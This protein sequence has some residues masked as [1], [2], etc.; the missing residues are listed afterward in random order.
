MITNPIKGLYVHIPFC[1]HICSYCDFYKLVNPKEHET[2]VNYLLKE[3]EQKKEF[4]K[5]IET[6]YIGG[7]TPSCLNVRLLQKIIHSLSNVLSLD[8]IN[9]W[10]IEVDPIHITSEW[11]DFINSTPITRLSIG[12]Q[13]LNN[14][15]LKR[16][17]RL[18]QKETALYALEL[19]QNKHFDNISVD[20]IYGFEEDSLNELTEEIQLF[21]EKNVKHISLYSL[22]LEEHTLL[23]QQFKKGLFKPMPDDEETS[24][25]D[26]LSMIL[27]NHEYLPYEIS[28][29][30][31]PGYE[32]KHN[33]IYWNN[34][35][36]LGIGAGASYYIDN[37]R[38]TMT[39]KLS[40][41]YQGIDQESYNFDEELVLSKQEQMEEEVMLGLRKVKGISIKHFQEKFNENIFNIYP[42]INSLLQQ[43][44]LQLQDEYLSIPMNH[45]YISNAILVH[46]FS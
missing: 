6:V 4:M 23:Y 36:Y 33:L 27:K 38:Y 8:Q 7:G 40:S 20:L 3:I 14:Q 42:N 24:L 41:Y 17:K 11:I 37:K 1:E 12:I 22:Q 44:F 19:L 9:E 39:K 16:M 46:I 30:S 5:N 29:F 34:E 25:Y 21:K 45:L 2:Y 13:S 32:S 28:N 26:A 18:H 15:K 10:T 35:H 43:H 31:I